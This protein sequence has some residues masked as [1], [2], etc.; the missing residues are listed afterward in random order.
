MTVAGGQPKHTVVSLKELEER[1]DLKQH[2]EAKLTEFQ[3]ARSPHLQKFAQGEYQRYEQYDHT[4]TYV[5]L[6]PS[7]GGVEVPAFFSVGKAVLDLSGANSASKTLKKRLMGDFSFTQNGAYAIAELARDDRVSSET[8]PGK[9][10]LSEALDV[11]K[12][13]RRFIGGRFIIV[14]SQE[15]VFE[16]LYQP[17]G[18]RK[19]GLSEPPRGME[20]KNF[21]TS[22]LLTRAL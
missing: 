20:G 17:Y 2:V 8:L 16:S 11:V 14:D 12:A 7:S 1:P 22:V 9:V 21:V 15:K 10:I 5:F 3:C 18:F 13:A 19:L 6:A 4:R